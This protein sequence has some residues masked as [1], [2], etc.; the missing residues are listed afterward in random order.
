MPL[1]VYFLGLFLPIDPEAAFPTSVVLSGIALFAL[2]ATKVLIT[3]R[4]WFRSG[5]EMLHVG[6]VAA[7]VAYLI[8]FL[9]SG[10]GA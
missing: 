5:P 8:G 1:L 3:E 4:S 7:A 2:G 9:L 10:L 6:G